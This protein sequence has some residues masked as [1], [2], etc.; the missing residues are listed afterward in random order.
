VS[1]SAYKQEEEDRRAMRLP[2]RMKKVTSSFAGLSASREE[3]FI[4]PILFCADSK[5]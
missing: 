1:A 2:S 4:S 3:I 5:G